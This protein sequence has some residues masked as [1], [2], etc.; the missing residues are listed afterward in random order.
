MAT[1][2]EDI[3]SSCKT[4]G[5]S[6]SSLFLEE[7]LPFWVDDDGVIQFHVPEELSC[8]R[9]GEKL[10]IQMISPYVPLVHIRNGTLGSKGHVCS[11]PQNVQEVCTHLPRIP[12]SVEFVKMVR[13]FKNDDGDFGI[14]AFTIRRK[15]VLAALR[16]L[17]KYNVDYRNEVTI[18]EENFE[19][20]DGQ[21]EAELP[22]LHGYE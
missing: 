13:K 15:E 4:Q 5:S 22:D 11:F 20:M 12:S 14:K 6:T 9:E 7:L 8:L 3:C 10:L 2:D 19:W 1:G 21:D 18:V 17:K 16:W